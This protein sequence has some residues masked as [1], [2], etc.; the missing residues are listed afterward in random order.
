[1]HERN[2]MHL[3][4]ILMAVIFISQLNSIKI[5]T[6]SGSALLTTNKKLF[7]FPY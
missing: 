4:R 1:M 2:C 5:K 7:V 6:S 3:M